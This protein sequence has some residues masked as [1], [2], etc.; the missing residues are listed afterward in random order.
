M[1]FYPAVAFRR[2]L[3]P[4]DTCGGPFATYEEANDALEHEC[5]DDSDYGVI[6]WTNQGYVRVY[7]TE[8]GLVADTYPDPSWLEAK[9]LSSFDI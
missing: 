1:K 3:K 7:E 6:A 9:P 8:N 2:E 5:T 4:S